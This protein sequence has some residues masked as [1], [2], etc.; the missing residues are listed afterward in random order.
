MLEK[1][2]RSQGSLLLVGESPLK[3]VARNVLER[4]CPMQ[5]MTVQL[6]RVFT[7]FCKYLPTTVNPLLSP[8]PPFSNK[9]PL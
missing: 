2:T 1:E 7:F 8:Q 6:G 3:K 5:M 4:S 9:P